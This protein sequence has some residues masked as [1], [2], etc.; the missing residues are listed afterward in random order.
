ML[1]IVDDFVHRFN[2][3]DFVVIADFL[4]SEINRAMGIGGLSSYC[5]MG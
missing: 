5:K 2:L 4:C 3:S 1:P